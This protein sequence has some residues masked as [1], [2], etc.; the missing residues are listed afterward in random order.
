MKGSGQ[1]AIGNATQCAGIHIRD[2][3]E[4]KLRIELRRGQIR[5]L[6]GKNVEGSPHRWWLV[7]PLS[8]N[9]AK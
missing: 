1:K 6:Y 2:L 7:E 8:E 4:R 9:E 3:I 5:S